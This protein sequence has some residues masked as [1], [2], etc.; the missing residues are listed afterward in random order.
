MEFLS[1]KGNCIGSSGSS[2]VKMPH[3]LRSHVAAQLICH[4][5]LGRF[6]AGLVGSIL[7][8]AKTILKTLLSGYQRYQGII[9]KTLLSGYQGYQGKMKKSQ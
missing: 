7:C 4:F 5:P 2:A 9:L 6:R 1:L 3:C 8:I